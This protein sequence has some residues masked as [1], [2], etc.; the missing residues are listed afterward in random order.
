MT[1]GEVRVTVARVCP[2]GCKEGRRQVKV[3]GQ[4][5]A[6]HR[7][8]DGGECPTCHGRGV[9]WEPV[10]C[11]GCRNNTT[12]DGLSW[13]VYHEDQIASEFACSAWEPREPR[14]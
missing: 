2:A 1:P 13:C 12:R 4:T 14:S 3:I 8:R 6:Q 5:R 7:F 11:A 9:V 10:S